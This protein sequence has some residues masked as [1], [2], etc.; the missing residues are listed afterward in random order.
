MRADGSPV[1]GRH[2]VALVLAAGHARR[3]GADK[4][5]AMLPNGDTVISATLRAI[6]AAGLDCIVVQS[7]ARPLPPGLSSDPAPASLLIP[8]AVAARGIGASLATAA[9]TLPDDTDIIVCLADMPHVQPS[10]YAAIAAALKPGRIVCPR[11]AG[12]RGNPVGF[13]ADFRRE[14]MLLDGDRGARDLLQR[15]DACVDFIDVDDAGIHIDIDL[16]GDLDP[17]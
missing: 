6:A 15:H 12:R 14:L 1:N 9:R 16:P 2:A 8:E 13:A 5:L 7:E 17:A 3:F 10:T 11:H 4:R